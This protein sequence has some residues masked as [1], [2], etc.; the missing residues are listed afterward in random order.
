MKHVLLY[1]VLLFSYAS[2]QNETKNQ[3]AQP[4]KNKMEKIK[5]KSAIEKILFYYRDA[6][7]HLMYIK[8]FHFKQPMVYVC[9]LTRFLHQI[10]NKLKVLI[11]RCFLKIG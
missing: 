8:Y 3:L 2:W 6:L 10:K 5:E 9:L 1:G 4:T 11:S 7:M